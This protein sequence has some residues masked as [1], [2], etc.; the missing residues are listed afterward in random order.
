MKK[1]KKKTK[2][3][4][5]LL[6]VL[7]ILFATA[8]QLKAQDKTKRYPIASAKVTYTISSPEGT[9]TK[10]LFLTTTDDVNLHRKP[11]KSAGKRLRIS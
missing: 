5:N 9:G 7:I 11:F 10:V 6:P 4:K 1:D 3:L 8:F 2:L